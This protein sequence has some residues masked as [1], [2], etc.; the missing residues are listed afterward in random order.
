VGL[1]IAEALGWIYSSMTSV[2]GG[3]ATEAQWLHH[4]DLR[5]I[6]EDPSLPYPWFPAYKYDCEDGRSECFHSALVP[7]SS[8]PD[9]LKDESWD[10]SIGSGV[11]GT[12]E[13]YDGN[14]GH[15]EKYFSHGNDEGIEPLVIRRYFHQLKPDIL[16]LLQE[17]SLFHN[18]YHEPRKKRYVH[19]DE[20][21]NETVAVRYDEKL[22]EIRTDLVLKFC[23]TKKMA[24]ALYIDSHRQSFNDLESIGC[25]EIIEHQSERFFAYNWSI[26]ED[27]VDPCSKYQTIGSLLGKKY[28]V[29]DPAMV[30]ADDEDFQEFIIGADKNGQ[31]I[32]HTCEPSR[33]A[34]YFGR[35][36]DAPHFLTPVYFRP[37]VLTKYY[38]NPDK[39][40]VE[41]GHLRCGGLWGLRMDNDHEDCVMAFLGDLG[42][43]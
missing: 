11:P 18:L 22:F 24:V 39:Y 26:T 34:N 4:D 23:K 21:G 20:D 6:L 1:T 15:E 12:I 41:D 9:L 8:I 38:S 13:Y 33:L 3:L 36:P 37:E 5:V 43:L 30:G 31:P 32:K 10:I 7:V 29:P 35:N 25:K 17:F 27:T 42:T 2:G 40:S 16:E 28:V 19:F 14:G